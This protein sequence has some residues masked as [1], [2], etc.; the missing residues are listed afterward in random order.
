MLVTI[1]RLN[2][3]DMEQRRADTYAE[4]VAWASDKVP[5]HM[6]MGPIRADDGQTTIGSLYIADFPSLEAARKFAN[7][8]PF[9]RAGIFK[10][11]IVQPVFN[12][13]A[14]SASLT[15]GVTPAKKAKAKSKR[16]KFK[17]AKTKPKSKG[18]AKTK[19]KAKPKRKAGRK[20]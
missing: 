4:H 11:I 9:T 14:A 7:D 13:A 8:D 3:P 10:Q 17:P 18:K 20:R 19:S 12:A 2:H 6:F 16:A 1:I 15:P 5:P